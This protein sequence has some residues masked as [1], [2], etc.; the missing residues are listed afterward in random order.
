MTEIRSI[1]AYRLLARILPLKY[2]L[3][4]LINAYLRP[5]D[6]LVVSY[7]KNFRI[8]IQPNS[9]NH[10]TISDLIFEGSRY[11]PEFAL[12]KKIKKELPAN[13]T[14]V[15]VGSNIGTTLW[16]FAEEAKKIYGYEPIP[17]LHATISDSISFNKASNIILVNKAIGNAEGFI[18]MLNSDNSNVVSE[19]QTDS[20]R[21]II[22]TLDA[23]LKNEERIDLIKID[24]EGFELKV[25][26]GARTIIK[27]HKPRLLVELH[28]GFIQNYGGDITGV[29]ACIENLDYSINY[30]S[31]LH[32]LRASRLNRFLNRFFLNSGKVFLSKQDFLDDIVKKPELSSY[33]IYCEPH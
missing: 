4:F 21:S 26:E 28:P 6:R 31:F 5:G 14:Y 8:C 29:I 13:F 2:K 32:D 15:D 30:Y 12:I 33:H 24:V 1:R 19:D 27:Q 17:H 10:R 9:S 25:L 11:L 16:L 23:E 3:N 20:V 7:H 22:T 18:N